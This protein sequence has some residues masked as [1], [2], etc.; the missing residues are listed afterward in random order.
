M[1]DFL[2]NL[3][4]IIIRFLPRLSFIRPNESGVFLRLG[5]YRKTV[6]EGWYVLLP[7]ID[8]IISLVVMPQVIN[9]PNQSVT[10]RDSVSVAVSGAIEYSITDAKK[11]LLEVQNFDASLQNLAMGI[12]SEYVNERTMADCLDIKSLQR[13]VLSGIRDAARGWGLKIHRFYLTD[14]VEHRAYRIMT[15]DAPTIVLPVE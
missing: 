5:H 8:D 9:L 7:L 13:A 1:N 10:T 2:N 12:I 3:L 6:S 14:L 11:A 4:Q 15:T